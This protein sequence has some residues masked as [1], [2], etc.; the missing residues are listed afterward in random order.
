MELLIPLI[1]LET[2]CQPVLDETDSLK[3]F[4]RAEEFE[5][6]TNIKLPRKNY[7]HHPKL[8]VTGAF[9]KYL[10]QVYGWTPCGC[11]DP[12]SPEIFNE[13]CPNGLR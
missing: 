6:L 9:R 3:L 12:D 8:W 2:F 10:E 7:D 4:E 13:W 1:F 11:K 5:T